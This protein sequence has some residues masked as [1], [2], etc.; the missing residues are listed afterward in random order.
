MSFQGLGEHMRVT[1]DRSL[2]RAVGLCDELA[3]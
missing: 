3:Y 2:P 1:R